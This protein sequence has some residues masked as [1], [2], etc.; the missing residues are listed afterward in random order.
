MPHLS[1][2]LI[3]SLLLAVLWLQ[4]FSRRRKTPTAPGALM[5][6]AACAL[7][8]LLVGLRWGG[9]F[10]LAAYLQ[11]L[12]AAT[13]PVLCW[14]CLRIRPL[15]H[16]TRAAGLHCGHLLPIIMTGVTIISRKILPWP[17]LDITL[18]AVY[19]GYGAALSGVAWHR[20]A[21]TSWVGGWRRLGIEERRCVGAGTFLILSGALD[22]AI[23]LD[24][25]LER[26]AHAVYLVGG[27]NLLTLM[28]LAVIIARM[29][30]IM[31]DESP[32]D[33]RPTPHPP[34]PPRASDAPAADDYHRAAQF[35]RLM[36]DE[37]LYA[38]PDLSILKLSKRLGLPVRQLSG[39]LNLVHGRNISQIINEY[40]ITE[41][42]R[43]LG[44]TDDKITDIMLASGFQTKSNF[45]R[46][47]RRVTGINPSEYR[48]TANGSVQPEIRAESGPGNC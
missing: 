26:G 3:N 38:D 36:R 2:P 28:L 40:R 27:A 19:L 42:I 16:R 1:L 47:F 30:N 5:F 44:A 23:A 43:L 11:P 39:A 20:D 48:T 9:G 4:L 21:A 14:Y 32:A 7:G 41:A 13:L 34:D 24:F 12:V 37:R 10:P 22:S 17:L 35:D 29:G 18:I 6:I 15:D 45:N 25:G 8:T 31:H 46:E 33:Q